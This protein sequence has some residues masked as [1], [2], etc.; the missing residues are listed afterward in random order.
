MNHE[1]RTP[2]NVI[3]GFAQLLSRHPHTPDEKEYFAT[4]QRSGEHLLTLIN[5]VLDLS[6][7]EADR[8]T[9]DE[10]TVGVYVLLDN[11]EDMF[12]LKTQRKGLRLRFERGKDVPQYI[13]AD[14]VKLRQVL[15]NL[16]SNAIKFTEKGAIQ[17]SVTSEQLSQEQPQQLIIGNCLLKF[18][19]SDTGPGIAPEELDTLFEAFTQTETGRQAHEGTGLGLVISQQFVRL[20]GGDIA[21]ESVV[22]EG[23]TFSFTVQVTLVESP[24]PNVQYSTPPKRVIGLKPDQ[25]A[26]S[27][28]ESERGH[29]RIL[30]VD[31]N[32]D[33][34]Q[35]LIKLLEDIGVPLPDSSSSGQLPLQQTNG[36]STGFDLREAANGQEAI[37]LWKTWQPHLVWMD[38]RMPDMDGYTATREIRKLET[39]NS[40]KVEATDP[41]FQGSSSKFQT[42]IIAVTVSSFEE[43]QAA[44]LSI[45]Y[46]DFLQ[47]PFQESAVCNLLHK[48]LGVQF[49]YEAGELSKEEPQEV[50][51]D[52]QGTGEDMLTPEALAE[53][54]SA[55]PE[56]LRMAWRNAVLAVDM[57]TAQELLQ[58]IRQHNPALAEALEAL[59]KQY[60]FDILQELFH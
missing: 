31:D 59:V 35:F 8:M 5:Q 13:R 6:K 36:L 11:L 39:R 52:Q 4:I 40:E 43:E 47:K 22:G 26:P 58:Q 18:E 28:K 32:S 60:R 25:F 7:I 21:V 48:H 33:N 29:F 56:T 16:L 57:Q 49:V 12:R 34:R 15:I 10:S 42:R 44:T 2:L 9:L 41:K 17:L 19:I 38:L 54:L 3:L 50:S 55:L 24:T 46:D 23:T 30:V 20:M 53:A 1:L 37:D 14:E 51:N 45:K 27:A